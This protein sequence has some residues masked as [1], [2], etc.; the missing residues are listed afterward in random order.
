M[1][2]SQQDKGGFTRDNVGHMHVLHSAAVLP[3]WGS[4]FAVPVALVGPRSV[5]LDLAPLL[6]HPKVQP[7]ARQGPAANKSIF[8]VPSTDKVQ[9]K[10][11]QGPATEKSTLDVPSTHKV[12]P[13]AR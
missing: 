3:D 5:P 4:R 7:N 13:S 6:G 12:Q 10:S 2:G 8:S 1:Q 9:P 11:R